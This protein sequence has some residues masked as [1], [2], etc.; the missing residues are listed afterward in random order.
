MDAAII[1]ARSDFVNVQSSAS[2]SF[3][4]FQ[5]RHDT[6]DEKCDQENRDDYLCA[7][8]FPRGIRLLA[9]TNYHIPA[10][11]Y[12][13]KFS[14]EVTHDQRFNYGLLCTVKLRLAGR[15]YRRE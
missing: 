7:D 14:K 12:P 13:V 8:S 3:E 15:D 5:D 4:C 10:C 6:R 11:H 1:F 9:W 2:T